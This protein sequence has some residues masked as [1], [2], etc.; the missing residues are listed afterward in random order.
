MNEPISGEPE[1]R[2]QGYRC[3]LGV[4]ISLGHHHS[5]FPIVHCPL[6]TDQNQN[7]KKDGHLSL[8]EID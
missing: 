8:G 7:P 6:S 3:L 2:E 1:A 4:T 5:P